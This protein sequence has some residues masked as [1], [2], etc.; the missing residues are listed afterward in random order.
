MR[1]APLDLTWLGSIEE[2]MSVEISAKGSHVVGA[3]TLLRIGGE[4]RIQIDLERQVL[5]TD[6]VTRVAHSNCTM[7]PTNPDDGSSVSTRYNRADWNRKM[8]M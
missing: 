1:L 3:Y 6:S 4:M 7:H 8:S 5:E 2:E